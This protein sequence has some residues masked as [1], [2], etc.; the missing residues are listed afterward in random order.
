MMTG[1]KKSHNDTEKKRKVMQT[2]VKTGMMKTE[3]DTHKEK[4]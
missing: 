1:R 3:K 4:D 2:G